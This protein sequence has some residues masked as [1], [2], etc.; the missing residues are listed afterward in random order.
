MKREVAGKEV[1]LRCQGGATCPV[2]LASAAEFGEGSK[3][4]LADMMRKGGF[5]PKS[6]FADAAPKIKPA[7]KRTCLAE[8]LVT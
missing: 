5:H 6:R 8:T 2:Y 3:A 4:F 1:T 7:F